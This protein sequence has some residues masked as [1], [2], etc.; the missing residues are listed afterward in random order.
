MPDAAPETASAAAALKSHPGGTAVIAD[1]GWALSLL[2]VGAAAKLRLILRSGSPLPYLDQWPAEGIDV[3][4]PWLRHQFKPGI[5]F[6]PHNEHRIFF[7]R[8]CELGLLILNRQWDARLEMVA[9]AFIHSLA[10]AGFGWLMASLLGRRWWPVLWLM[11]ALDLALPFAWENTLWGFQSQF[12][13]LFIFSML[14][15]WLLA[16][17]RPLSLRW[18]CGAAASVAAL[19][20]MASGFLAAAAA[21]ALAFVRAIREP[22][23]RRR[24]LVTAAWCLCVIAVGI[25]LKPDIPEHHMF[26]AHS[27][28]DFFTALGKNLAWPWVIFPFWA[29]FNLLPLVALGC[30]HFRSREDSP[31]ERMVLGVGAWTILQCLAVAWSRGAGGVNPAWRYMDPFSFLS[32]TGCLALCLLLNRHRFRL[33]ILPLWQAGVVVWLIGCLTGLW[34]LT[35]QAPAYIADNAVDQAE[36]L[37]TARAF[38]ATGDA[39][40]LRRTRYS[41]VIVPNIDA[42]VWLLRQPDLHRVLP[43]CLRDPCLVTPAP[44]TTGFAT[45]AAR[46]DKP[47]PPSEISWGSFTAQGAANRGRFESLP[48]APGTLPYIEIPVAGNLGQPGLSLELVDAASGK[49]TA[50]TPHSIPGGQWLDVQVPAPPAA[51][52]IV[53]VDDS[54][55]GWFAFKAPRELG[56]LSYW[57]LRIASSWA[58]LL[59]LGLCLLPLNLIALWRRPRSGH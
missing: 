13:F 52:K 12:Y 36:Q 11:L 14:T 49:I 19:F 28:G 5:L 57:S 34:F 31:A 41:G 17:G 23:D 29:P 35:S 55:A 48:I 54:D 22:A 15:L 6:A 32:V 59:A 8:L 44:G 20:T 45:K 10:V 53:A 40:A 18:W 42:V 43:A 50:V 46:L 24:H 56:L 1:A 30:A 4:W 38:I 2:L 27:A 58:C 21:G 51:F 33:P 37:K 3:F 9:N 25:H 16:T 26:Q 39:E 47:D 7:T